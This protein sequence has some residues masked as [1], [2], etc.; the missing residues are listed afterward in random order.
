VSGA[1]EIDARPG[2]E[3]HREQWRTDD[4]LDE[5]ENS[6]GTDIRFCSTVPD[7][8]QPPDGSNRPRPVQGRLWARLP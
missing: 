1:D 7:L 2:F 6:A 4:R 5:Q 8:D 3:A